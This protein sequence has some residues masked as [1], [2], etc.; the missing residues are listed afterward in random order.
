MTMALC[1]CGVACVL[2]GMVQA[3]SWVTLLVPLG[4]A[5]FFLGSGNGVLSAHSLG[6][7]IG[8][9][10]G[11][12]A[13]LATLTQECQ[14][15]Q[16]RMKCLAEQLCAD[17]DEVTRT[18]DLTT[19]QVCRDWPLGTGTAFTVYLLC[20]TIATAEAQAVVYGTTTKIE[21]DSEEERRV[22]RALHDLCGLGVAHIARMLDRD[23]AF[24]RSVLGDAAEDRS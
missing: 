3:G 24:V 7:I 16:I 20:R 15:Q 21:R 18:I 19:V 23:V 6:S 2:A 13:R 9:V 10:D 11:A 12:R 1:V 17:K 22:I 5:L 14:E 8:V 4:S